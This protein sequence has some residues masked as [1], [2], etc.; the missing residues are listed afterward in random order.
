MTRALARSRFP[1]STFAKADKS[2]LTAAPDETQ[3]Y[4][5]FDYYGGMIAFRRALY[6]RLGG[7][8]P[9][10]FMNVEESDLAVRILDAG[11]FIKLG[12]APPIDHHESPVRVSKRINELG[13]RNNILYAWYNVPM[14]F[15][16]PHILGAGFLAVRHIW[17]VGF[18][19]DAV[20]GWFQ[21]WAAVA[22]ELRHRRP[23]SVAGY[24][25]SREIKARGAV[26]LGE[27]EARLK[28]LKTRS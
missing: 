9:F 16:L 28:A 4:A 11:Y 20:R 15:L 14:P 24:Q 5:A 7:Y 3:T 18:P 26:P 10:Y 12:T 6:L 25:L 17:R 19:G 13:P 22:H 27:I 2:V 8:R 1:L 23:V 21:G